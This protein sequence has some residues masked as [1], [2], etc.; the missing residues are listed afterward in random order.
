MRIEE[1]F[2]QTEPGSAHPFLDNPVLPS[3]IE[4]LFP[5]SS[6]DVVTRGLTSLGNNI[7]G[8]IRELG[9]HVSPPTLTQYNHFGRRVDELHTSEGWRAL[10]QVAAKE[11]IVSTA[12]DRTYGELSRVLMFMKVYIWNAESHTVSCPM[13][14]TDGAARVLELIGTEHMKTHLL[15]RLL[16]RDPD[17]SF[18]AG[19]WMTE[20]PGG[21]DVSRTETTATP[22][23]IESTLENGAAYTLSGVK[24]FSSATDGQLALALAQLAPAPS[25]SISPGLGLFLVPLPGVDISLFTPNPTNLPLQPH[26]GIHIHRLKNKIGTHALPTAELTLDG[27]IGFL[28]LPNTGLPRAGSPVRPNGVRAIAPVLNITRLHSAAS[29]TGH[30]ARC[31]GIAKEYARVRRVAGAKTVGGRTGQV[32]LV[33]VPLHTATLARVEVLS[34]ALTIFLFGVVRLL[35]RVETGSQTGEEGRRL[36]LLTPVLK[37]FTAE[38]AVGGMEECMASLGGLGYMEET[39]IGRLIRDSLVE[40]IWEGTTNVLALDMLRAAREDSGAPVT[41]FYEWSDEIVSRLAPQN[42]INTTPITRALALLRRVFFSSPPETVARQALL[43]V[44]QVACA[45]Y[46]VEHALWSGKD[47]DLV[48]VGRWINEGGLGEAVEGVEKCLRDGKERETWDKE[49]VYGPAK[50]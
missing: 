42:S 26:N 43:L 2:H 5:E 14:M 44:G 34:R 12:Y 1:G 20:R 15:P 29:S 32:L 46:L 47:V 24:W 7:N 28:L 38:Y 35:G 48:V 4:R 25:N 40:K 22:I 17:L 19:Q 45:T 3:I 37:A 41:A 6:K 21:S 16:S 30:L 11:G 10:K 9:T 39:G 23:R 13:A 49:I 8:Y 27:T 50:L 36:R 33:D 31:L 18:T